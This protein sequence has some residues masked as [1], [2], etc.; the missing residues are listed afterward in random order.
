MSGWGQ[1][2]Q[3]LRQLAGRELAGSAGSVAELGQ[4][5][6]WAL[7]RLALR[8]GIG[9]QGNLPVNR[10]C[11]PGLPGALEPWPV[12]LASS[13]ASAPGGGP[14]EALAPP[15]GPAGTPSLDLPRNGAR[16]SDAGPSPTTRAP[17]PSSNGNGSPRPAVQPDRSTGRHPRD[18]V[19][20]A[21]GAAAVSILAVVAAVHPVS[22]L[23]ANVFSEIAKLPSWTRPAFE[24]IL[25]LGSVAAIGIAAGVALFLHRMRL[26]L[27]LVLAG[28][29][30]WGL[31]ATIYE[32]MGPR[33]V[34]AGL[35]P[36][37]GLGTSVIFP[38]QHVAVA[39]ALATV[40]SPYLGRAL[41]QVLWPLV[42]LVAL[43]E[44]F[45]ANHLPLDVVAGAFLGWWAGTAV[46]LVSGAPG[47][48][49]SVALV[50]HALESA[51][52]A[53][54]VVVPAGP[55]PWHGLFGPTGFSVQTER[56][57]H[58]EVEVVRAGQH[59]AGLWYRLRRLLASLDVE[60]QPRLSSAAH[61]VEHEAFITL[62]AERAGVRTP[63]VVLARELDHGP[64]LLI[65]RR[66]E[67]QTLSNAE[68]AL[69]DD[70]VLADLWAQVGRLGAAGIAHRNLRADNIVVDETG[71]VAICD[72]TFARAGATSSQ[73]A[74][75]VTEALVSLA[76]VVGADRAVDSAT[77]SVPP[78]RLNAALHYLRSLALPA[79]IRRQGGAGRPPIADLRTLMADRLDR[80][81]PQWRSPVRPRTILFLVGSGAAVYL[82]LPQLGTV[83]EVLRLIR[84]ANYGWLAASLAFGAATFPMAAFSYLGAVRRR[85][86]FGWTTLTQLASAFTSRLTPGGV[87]GMGLNLMYLE[88]QGMER[89]EAAGA[90]AL[91]QTAGA[92]VHAAGFFLAA[93]ALG[94]SGVL[95]RA[96]L[97]PRWVVLVVVL[98]VL[99]AAGV[100]L[101]SPFGRRRLLE[102]GARVG[103]QL[104]DTLRHPGRAAMLLGG[105]AGVTLGNGFGLVAALYA[106][107][108]HF[109]P[110]AVLA[111]YVGG[112]ALAAPAPTPGNIGA[113]EAALAAGLTGIGIPVAPAVAA[114]LSF[115][116]LTFWLPMVPGAAALRELQHR[117]MV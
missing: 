74:Q 77:R 2:T 52:L 57:D 31:S 62:L 105:S 49:T 28:T 47:R 104:V 48:R 39:G 69:L 10:A 96:N 71:Q 100:V 115:R 106:F 59:R 26:A 76:S 16:P 8:H 73:L 84:R 114:V 34:P 30:A 117:R 80:S 58:L 17:D 53:P 3:D 21:I 27:Q 94:L 112:S 35:L 90:V 60:I 61:K 36:G 89:T 32:V 83:P 95:H 108:P 111:V 40:V 43:G 85:L 1:T 98:G 116:L 54:V 14:E 38:A 63:E 37:S 46:D 97:P 107:D 29:L 68:P 102:P 41:R 70:E 13:S 75:D 82:L 109:N 91:N 15:L 72:F 42:A 7:R 66:V 50:H 103:R 64:A 87:G 9:H 92:V 45:L 5:A 113:V 33:A 23:E 24:A 56:G 18:V 51:G 6:G 65:R 88:R 25:L 4:P 79:R 20:L 44:I 78:D 81:V 67:G 12:A 22:A 11:S 99:V 110:L 101:G 55:G 86:P 93:A 19:R